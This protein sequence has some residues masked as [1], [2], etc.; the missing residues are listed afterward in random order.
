MTRSGD[1]GSPS[2]NEAATPTQGSAGGEL[3]HTADAA[4]SPTPKAQRTAGTAGAFAG[5]ALEPAPDAIGDR[6]VNISQRA[7]FSHHDRRA[8][9]ARRLPCGRRCSALRPYCA[10]CLRR[11]PHQQRIAWFTAGG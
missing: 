1:G 3:P 10:R 8:A 9:C 2:A 11:G 5:E 7:C 6:I 4:S